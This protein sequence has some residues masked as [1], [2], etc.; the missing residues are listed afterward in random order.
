MK[1]IQVENGVVIFKPEP[2]DLE[3]TT[4]IREVKKLKQDFKE[5]KI[6]IEFIKQNRN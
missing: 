3:M 5:L 2:K 6:E 1:R 4:L